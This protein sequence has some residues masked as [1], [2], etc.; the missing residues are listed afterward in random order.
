MSPLPLDPDVVGLAAKVVVIGFTAGA[1][2][3]TWSCLALSARWSDL[4]ERLGAPAA[5]SSSLR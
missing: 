3:L 5:R 4:E 2:L 1:A